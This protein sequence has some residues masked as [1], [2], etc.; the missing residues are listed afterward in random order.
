MAR[1][2][3]VTGASAGIGKSVAEQFAKDGI[4]LIIT[5]RSI[6]RLEAIAREWRERYEVLVTPI[7]SDL[8]Q[9]GGAQKLFDALAGRNLRID[10][11]VNNAGV[12]VFG[13]FRESR[14]DEI[15]SMLRLNMIALTVLTKLFLEQ[16]IDARGKIMNVASMAGFVP[17]PY[18]ANYFATKAYVLSFSQALGYELQGTGVTVTA[19]CPGVTQTEFFDQASMHHSRMVNKRLPTADDVGIAGYRAMQRGRPVYIPGLLDRVTIQGL[20]FTP[21]WLVRMISGMVTA[22]PRTRRYRK[23]AVAPFAFATGRIGDGE[24]IVHSGCAFYGLQA[25]QF[26]RPSN[27]HNRHRV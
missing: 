7:Q 5:S 11:L 21:R 26:P 20:R 13:L 18:M 27:R 14:L 4:N 2:A 9:V 25:F 15:A 19:L 16:I 3:L 8:A 12:G 6:D 23:T 24:P 1:T 17:G 22:L 10:Y